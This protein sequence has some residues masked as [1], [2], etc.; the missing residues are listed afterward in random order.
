MTLR[1]LIEKTSLK[2][3]GRRIGLDIQVV[4]G[5]VRTR[6]LYPE[7]PRYSTD[8]VLPSMRMVEACRARD[9][10]AFHPFI[11]TGLLTEAQMQHAA[12]RYHLGLTRSG[13]P[14]YWMIDEMLEPLDAHITGDT[15]L[16]TLLR[17]RE[18]LLRG[19]H[20]VHCLYGLHLLLEEH[21]PQRP[22]AIVE[23]EQSATVLSELFP[24][25]L[26]MA[27]ATPEHLDIERFA[28]LAGRTVTFYPRT[29]TGMSHFLLFED[30]AADLRR[31]YAIPCYVD[32][33]LEEH[34]TDDQRA[35]GIDLLGFLLEGSGGA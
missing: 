35:R 23:S 17:R 28:P 14:M 16:S 18:P 13:L 8:F 27:Y 30:V 7:D 3:I 4:D 2:A 24:E 9:L 22:V 29:D 1:E 5:L 20:P 19:W 15:W 21:V 10:S 12:R 25:T 33:T 31:H 11:E 26:W 32:A 6:P 34:A